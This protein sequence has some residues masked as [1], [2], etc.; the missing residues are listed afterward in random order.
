MKKHHEIEKDLLCIREF[1]SG[2]ILKHIRIGIY[3]T[4]GINLPIPPLWNIYFALKRIHPR[5]V[6][7]AS[8]VTLTLLWDLSHRVGASFHWCVDVVSTLPLMLLSLP[9]CLFHHV[10]LLSAARLL[11]TVLFFFT[12]AQSVMF[13]S[14]TCWCVF[15]V[16]PRVAWSTTA[17]DVL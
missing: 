12:P 5:H 6:S 3:D 4:T 8:V 11:R 14:I 1:C 10:V 2:L 15:H 7:S 16:D 17:W 9:T 13:H